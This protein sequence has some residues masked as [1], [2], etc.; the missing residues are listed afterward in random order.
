MA[1]GISGSGKCSHRIAAERC[2]ASRVRTTSGTCSLVWSR[3]MTSAGGGTSARTWRMVSTRTWSRPY[4]GIATVM[5]TDDV[6]S[7]LARAAP[8]QRHTISDK[9]PRMAFGFHP[10][11]SGSRTPPDLQF[12]VELIPESPIGTRLFLFWRAVV[13][14][15]EG[16]DRRHAHR[17][18]SS[19]ARPNPP[20]GRERGRSHCLHTHRS[21]AA[22]RY[23]SKRGCPR[24]RVRE[25]WQGSGF[26]YGRFPQWSIGFLS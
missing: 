6:I 4:V 18:G 20:K 2:H 8:L 1:R 25:R 17:H 19:N 11:R 14:N 21:V 15:G 23:A 5:E 24:E 13:K 9:Q 7:S 26:R 22:K 12:P 10:P 3:T 16:R